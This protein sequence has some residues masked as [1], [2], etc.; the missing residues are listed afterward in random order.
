VQGKLDIHKKNEI[1]TLFKSYANKNPK[2]IQNYKITERK[3][4]ENSTKSLW[5]MI[6]LDVICKTQSATKTKSKIEKWN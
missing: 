6:F 3:Y 5:A 1:K 4:G 2:Q